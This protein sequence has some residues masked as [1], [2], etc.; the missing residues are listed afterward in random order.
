MTDF[1]TRGQVPFDRPE[2]YVQR[3]ADTQFDDYLRRNDYIAVIGPRLSGKTSLLVRKYHELHSRQ[4]ALPVYINLSLL[5][6]LEETAWYAR[7]FLA[8]SDGAQT[9]G[10]PIPRPAYPISNELD[11]RDSLLDALEDQLKARVLVVILDDV[12]TIPKPLLTP[13][14]AMIREMFSSRE[15]LP[16]F[17][18]CVW[19][20]AGCFIPDDLIDD[21][22]ISPFRV[23]ERIHMQDTDSAGVAQ[24]VNLLDTQPG[25]PPTRAV[26]LAEYVHRWTDGDL[27]LTQ[28]LCSLLSHQTDRSTATVDRLASQTLTEDDIFQRVVRYVEHNPRILK[29]IHGIQTGETPVRFTRLQRQIADA[30]L[31]GIIKEDAEG[32]CTV[33]NAVYQTILHFTDPSTVARPTT[34]FNVTATPPTGA[35][36][37]APT[38][39]LKGR[40]RLES[41][42][43]RG[44]MA[45][46][47]RANDEITGEAVAV[48]QLL[49]ELTHDNTLLERFEREGSSLRELSHPNIVHFIDL[50]HEGGHPY[51][52]MEYVRGGTLS[53]LMH[54]EGRSLPLATTLKIMSG[55]FEALAHAHDH[56]IIHRDI[57]P[58]N[59]LL[60]ADYVTRLADFGVARLITENRMTDTGLVLGTVPYMSPEACSGE[61]VSAAT[62]L[63]SAGVV[64]FEVLTGYLPYSGPNPASTVNAIMNAPLPSLSAI[65]PDLPMAVVAIIGRLLTRELSAR[66]NSAEA[67][68]AALGALR[69]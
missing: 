5:A 17:K 57:K 41:V 67:V 42:L 30:W 9:A 12:E 59:I 37:V 26:N 53:Q 69:V 1:I 18:R 23:A 8:I 3:P 48:K 51:L 64:F 36:I 31:A 6:K 11:L 58:G 65:R 60:T 49:G 15:M 32:N 40:Y 50:F 66:Y 43:G 7:L 35:V 55:L 29:M 46:V 63:W 27:Y 54:R 56:Q 33:R 13:L 21:P 34:V 20:L 38:H 4:R 16:A 22:S 52:V 62:D 24:L 44:G 25:E 2:V 28:R 68:S 14:M 19:I 61:P 39:P 10:S 47:Y 45:Q